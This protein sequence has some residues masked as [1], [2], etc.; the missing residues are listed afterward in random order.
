MLLG[1][2]VR[3]LFCRVRMNM[4][5]L[6]MVWVLMVGVLLGAGAAS[7]P[8]EEAHE[9]HTPT[10]IYYLTGATTPADEAGIRGAVAKEKTAS[11]VEVNLV[12][13][14]VRVKFDSHV[15]SYHEVAQA[16]ADAG[17]ALSGKSM[18]RRVVVPGDGLRGACESSGW[19]FCGEEIEHA[20]ACGGGG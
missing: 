9:P 13:S 16:L 14:Y 18:I 5:R 11:V 17:T 19:D 8:F 4:A 7:Q 20:G 2:E 3:E 10:L 15:V 6:R 12:R 1:K